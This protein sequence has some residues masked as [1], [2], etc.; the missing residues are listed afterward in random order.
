M[1]RKKNIFDMIGSLIPGYRG[2][3]ERESRRHSDK[4]L[5]DKIASSI[6]Y[7]EKLLNAQIRIEL[8]NRN[9]EK[10]DMLDVCRKKLNTLSSRIKYIPYG[11]SAFFSN[12]QLKEEEL[13]QIYQKDLKLMEFINSLKKFIQS[14]IP[15]NILTKIANI[16]QLLENRSQFIRRFK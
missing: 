1:Q 11:E 14:M 7:Y 8:K 10:S 16:E 9:F 2:Y 15:D 12:S 5:R 13:L 6:N 4:I 3:A